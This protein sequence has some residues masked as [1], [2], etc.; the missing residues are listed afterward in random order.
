MT[1]KESMD[2]RIRELIKL[3]TGSLGTKAN[4]SIRDLTWSYRDNNSIT[5]LYVELNIKDWST[6]SAS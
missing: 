5:E 3:L 2:L 4:C 6:L 1:A